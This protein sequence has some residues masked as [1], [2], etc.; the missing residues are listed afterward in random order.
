MSHT[1]H[2]LFSPK[3]TLFS[4]EELSFVQIDHKKKI[5]SITPV[6]LKIK[7]NAFINTLEF[8]FELLDQSNIYV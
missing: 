7:V 3:T 4:T 6:S 1:L 8:H 5:K 2:G